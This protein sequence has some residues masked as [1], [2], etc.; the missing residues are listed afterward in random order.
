VRGADVT[1]LSL[2]ELLGPQPGIELLVV[3]P[4]IEE[5]HCS[6]RPELRPALLARACVELRGER[7]VTR[8]PE[9]E[10]QRGRVERRTHQS[11]EPIA[12]SRVRPVPLG[13]CEHSGDAEP[14]PAGGPVRVIGLGEDSV[15]EGFDE[16]P[17]DETRVQL[18]QRP[19][20][21]GRPVVEAARGMLVFR[22]GVGLVQG[23]PSVGDV[24][25]TLRAPQDRLDDLAHTALAEC[26]P[27]ERLVTLG[28]EQH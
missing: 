7:H 1:T 12:A 24:Q 9:H 4:L 25:L 14:D 20:D 10:L 18:A 5:T 28:R 13:H 15:L 11:G 27:G 22:I 16:L 23:P 6:G 26:P 17:I 2:A 19:G 8:M 3:A 21:A